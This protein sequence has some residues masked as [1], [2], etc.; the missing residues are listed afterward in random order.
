MKRI[1][2]LRAVASFIQGAAEILH[3]EAKVMHS[4]RDTTAAAETPAAGPSAQALAPTPRTRPS[5]SL[6]IEAAEIEEPAANVD[7]PEIRSIQASIDGLDKEL[8]AIG[9]LGPEPPKATPA[10]PR[11]AT[12]AQATTT[13][14]ATPAKNVDRRLTSD[15]EA[16]VA[17]DAELDGKIDGKKNDPAGPMGPGIM[18]LRPRTFLD[19]PRKEGLDPK[20]EPAEEIVVA[21]PATIIV[22][23]PKDTLVVKRDP[24]K[25]EK[26]IKAQP[27]EFIA[28]PI[29]DSGLRVLDLDDAPP[30]EPKPALEFIAPPAQGT[31]P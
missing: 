18:G 3:E 17:F 16:A 5:V 29:E 12:A 19:L 28:P 9:D 6:G 2:L 14:A 26:P 30:S 27:L 7:T 1:S 20:P 24:P 4:E 22:A 25:D 8:E 11:T 31:A 15:L 10:Q 13:A 21:R 23:E